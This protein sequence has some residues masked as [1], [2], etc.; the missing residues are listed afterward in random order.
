MLCIYNLL[1]TVNLEPLK[2]KS[3][4]LYLTEGKNYATVKDYNPSQNTLV[5][6][7]KIGAKTHFAK[8]TRVLPLN[9][10]WECCYKLEANSFVHLSPKQC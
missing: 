9:K 8:L 6:L 3:T 10:A 2:K 4:N 1:Q 7:G 5:H